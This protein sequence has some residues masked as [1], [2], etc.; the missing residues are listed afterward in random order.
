MEGIKHFE[1]APINIIQLLGWC[2]GPSA[3]NVKANAPC[4]QCISHYHPIVSGFSEAWPSRHGCMDSRSAMLVDDSPTL[5]MTFH[6][7]NTPEC[8]IG[9]R[10]ERKIIG[11]LPVPDY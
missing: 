4:L 11:R 9:G 8:P 6:A 7:A 1:W 10:K 2:Q 3:V 5:D